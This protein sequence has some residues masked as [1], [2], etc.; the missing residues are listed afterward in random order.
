METFAQCLLASVGGNSSLVAFPS[1]S[2]FSAVLHPYNLDIVT[3]P[4]AVVFPQT[5]NQVAKAVGCAV[6]CGVKVQARCGG[7][8]YGNYGICSIQFLCTGAFGGQEWL[9]LIGISNGELSVNLQDLNAFSLDA[10]TGRATVGGGTLL[11]QM[12]EELYDAG[13]RYLPHGL[14]FD[15]GV[16]GHATIGGVGV[17]SR[18]D[19]LLLDNLVEVEVVLADSSIVRASEF[20]NPEL[21]FAIRGAGAS[22]GIV[23]EFVFQSIPAPPS[24]VAYTY[25]WSPSNSTLRAEVHKAWQKWSAEVPLPRELSSTLTIRSTAVI[26]SGV[27]VGTKTEFE[28]L[29]IPSYFPTPESVTEDV[30][31]DYHQ[32][33]IDLSTE[34]A[35]A[36]QSSPSYFYAKDIIFRNETRIPD[37][38][39]D[40]FSQYLDTVPSDATFWVVNF[41]LGGGFL[42]TIPASATAFPHR[43]G[44][45]VALSYAQTSGSVSNTT[46][47]FLDGLNTVM[48]SGNPDAF[49]GQY[50][51]YIDPKEDADMARRGYWNTNLPKLEAI[52]AFLDPYDVFHNPQSVTVF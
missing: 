27:F 9:T 31:T 26:V 24:L 43:D 46:V 14:T 38:V 3:T 21:F 34:I 47:S 1:Q 20:L 2:T 7:H 30:Y 36:G 19:G 22:F 8:S 4:A 33:S 10:V 12:N 49:Y 40:Q 18:K 51:G 35:S 5:A 42:G 37:A 11:G 15:I 52:K 50:A 25:A 48:T 44:T 17:T 6:D 39:I 45:F 23:T 13:Q 29:N 41:E 32:L 28:T 16:G